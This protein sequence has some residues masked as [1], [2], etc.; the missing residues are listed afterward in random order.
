MGNI[1]N[2]RRNIAIHS[3]ITNELDDFLN[4]KVEG[5]G[6]TKSYII[7]YIL[8]SYYEVYNE[9]YNKNY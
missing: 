9:E 6:L 8:Q 1:K 3:K 7:Y 5:T 2:K 4:R